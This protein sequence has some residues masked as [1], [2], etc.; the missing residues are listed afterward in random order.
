MTFLISKWPV[1][2][3]LVLEEGQLNA[4][5]GQAWPR[6]MFLGRINLFV[7]GRQCHAL[8]YSRHS[9]TAGEVARPQ[10]DSGDSH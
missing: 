5:E 10:E 4:L 6:E 8:A 1:A 9:L 2:A 7:H 3:A